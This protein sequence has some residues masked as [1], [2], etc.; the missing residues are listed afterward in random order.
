MVRS[1]VARLAAPLCA[2]MRQQSTMR[3]NHDRMALRR[4][5]ASVCCCMVLIR[6]ASASRWT[7][8]FQAVIHTPTS[9]RP[10]SRA[11]DAHAAATAASRAC[12]ASIA[13]APYSKTILF[14]R[15]CLYHSHRTE[16]SS[17]I[18]LRASLRSICC[19][20]ATLALVHL[21]QCSSADA[22]SRNKR[23]AAMSSAS[24][25]STRRA[26]AFSSARRHWECHPSKARRRARLLRAPAIMS[27]AA[28]TAASRA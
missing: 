14:A 11:I 3:R 8:C 5:H 25:S 4:K 13:A 1:T 18:S 28:V 26:L 19:Q 27:Q 23:V 20:S 12:F 16:H 10:C 15:T 9:R 21:C 6:K 24:A 22:A 2:C 17:R 7:R